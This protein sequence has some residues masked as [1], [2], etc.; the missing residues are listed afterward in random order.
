M[1]TSPSVPEIKVRT[2]HKNSRPIRLFLFALIVT[3][4]IAAA[5]IIYFYPGFMHIEP[6]S[7]VHLILGNTD[8]GTN[9]AEVVRGE[10][11]L[12]IDV[13]KRYIDPD[14]FWEQ[15]T[16]KVIVTTKNKVIRMA[17]EAVTARVNANEISLQTPVVQ[18]NG[19][20]WIPINFLADLYNINI[21]HFGSSNRIV[22]TKTDQEHVEGRLHTK[23][24]LRVGPG[25]RNPWL[26]DL[27]KG[28]RVEVFEETN[29]YSFI[30]TEDGLLGYLKTSDLATQVIPIPV[31]AKK[32]DKKPVIWEP[33]AGEK[34][35]LTWE[36][37]YSRNP[38]TK[39]IPQ[40][41]GLNVVSPTWF[42]LSDNEGG[43]TNKA[44]SSY[45]FWAHQRG[46]QVWALFSNS[47]DKELTH[48]A[49]SSA[50]RREKIIDQMLIYA[51]LYDLDGINIDF[52][53]VYLQDKDLVV[54]FM[55]ELVPVAH[56]QGLVV[57]MDVTVKGGSE[58]YSL[59]YDRAALGDVVDYLILMTYDEHWSSS[60]IAGSVASLPWVEKGVLG[61]LEDVPKEKLVLG[62]PFYTR[63]WIETENKDGSTNVKSEALSMESAES[64]IQKNKA[65]VTY[66]EAAGQ[67]YAYWED[68]NT[69]KEIWLENEESMR[70]RAQLV[71]KYK[72]AGI[73][74]WRRGFEK[75]EI[76][77]VIAEELNQK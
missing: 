50:E 36:F 25:F 26:V 19:R 3:V 39:T 20:P 41:P 46:Y 45:V 13:I 57:S 12:P 24:K 2:R 51:E 72:L 21:S 6:D 77:Q 54:Q 8:L 59:F 73:A 44:S 34:I 18:K 56:Q 9:K 75:D 70:Q 48:A 14:I 37:V 71:D 33:A 61:L 47:F 58:T 28:A 76:W 1:N 17:T 62:V 63:L 10:V 52:E 64:L 16:G 49:L 65:K 35:N 74:S 68:G 40:I 29:D 7:E 22:L 43:I 38:D 30:R 23:S 27:V 5:A 11:F 69:T 32:E 60:P 31:E 66:D 42:A 55:R 15:E 53:N 67:R 4:I